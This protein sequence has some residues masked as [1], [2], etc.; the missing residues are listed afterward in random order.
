MRQDG[1]LQKIYDKY[2]SSKQ[3]VRMH[4]PI[5]EDSPN[6]HPFFHDL[7]FEAISEYGYNPFIIPVTAPQQRVK[8][9]LDAGLISLFWLVASDE[10]DKKYIPIE[11]GLTDGFIGKR[12]LFITK[13]EQH[14]YNNVET[15]DDFRKLNLVGGMGKGWFDV[16]VWKA[17]GL[18]YEEKDG[19]WK[20]IFKMLPHGRKYNYF[21]RG[22]N[23]ILLESRQYPD[24]EIEKRLML[25]YDRDFKF[26][27]ARSGKNAVTQ[28]EDILNKALKKARESGLIEKLVKKYWASDFE[29]LNIENRVKIKLQTPE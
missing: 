22:A 19:N 28:Y 26:Y 23:E 11:V 24:L 14:R 3:I 2:K 15:L 29:T 8:R 10:R 13:G 6:Q 12:I 25:V 4:V 21:S 20:A 16:K 27:L 18:K 1:R 5:I 17:N 9:S 7:L